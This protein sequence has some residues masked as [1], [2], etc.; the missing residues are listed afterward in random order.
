MKKKFFTKKR[1]KKGATT[2]IE[3]ILIIV[4]LVIVCVGAF[5]TLGKTMS[6]KVKDINDELSGADATGWLNGEEGS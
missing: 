4:V 3:I 1:L 2:M 6:G 5:S